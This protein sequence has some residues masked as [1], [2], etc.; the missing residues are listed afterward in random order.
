VSLVLASASPRRSELLARVGIAHECVPANIDETH[1]S[2]EAVGDYASRLARDKAL[3]V[4]AVHHD[5]WVLGAD[6]V[7]IVDGDLLGKP[8]DPVDAA[9]MLGRLAGRVHLVLTA[10]C[11]VAP[12]G[13]PVRERIVRSEVEFRALQPTELAAYIG[14]GEWRGK[15]GGY[16]V[17]GLASGFVRALR[18]SYTSV[19]GLPLCEVIEDLAMHAADGAPVARFEHGRPV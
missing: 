17:Q 13:H 11:L 7:V 1:R 5:R 4:S 15:A 19:V 10:T 6:T 16:A 18:G 14:S 3:R 9:V 8:E 12:G 2:G